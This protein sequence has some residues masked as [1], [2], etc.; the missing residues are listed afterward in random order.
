M[1]RILIGIDDT[2]N[3]DSRGTG[4][5]A[6][7]M[8]KLIVEN[9]LGLVEGISRHQLFFD[10][11]IP[12]TSHNSSACLDV[13]TDDLAALT[14]FSRKFILEDSALGSDAGLAIFKYDD[15]DEEVIKWG[16]RAKMEVLTQ[17]EAKE[18]AKRKNIYLEGLTGNRDGI[19]GALAAL[20]LRKS[21]NDGRLIW[22]KGKEIR[23]VKGVYTADKLLNELCVDV[24][25]DRSGI[26]IPKENSID[27]GEWVRPVLKKEKIIIIVDRTK[28][29]ESYEW[30]IATKEYIRSIS[31]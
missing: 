5:R 3:K 16:Q 10:P 25:T 15:I 19:I 24:I 18:I 21:A 6:R 20:G 12:Y 17:V 11:R 8:G 27:V 22:L 1:T 26:S 14:K 29:D 28:N 2:D 30:K 7:H 4:Y 31:N 23:D 13:L 9:N